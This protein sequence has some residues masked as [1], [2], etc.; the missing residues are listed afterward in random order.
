MPRWL[1]LRHQH[2]Q[3][4]AEFERK[5][6]A[7]HAEFKRRVEAAR[8]LLLTKHLREESQL[9]VSHAQTPGPKHAAT[10]ISSRKMQPGSG[11]APATP[12]R[13]GTTPA[14]PRGTLKAQQ[15]QKPPITPSKLSRPS[16]VPP[17]PGKL[18]DRPREAT[19]A[20]IDLCSD[21]EDDRP[22]ARRKPKPGVQ[23]PTARDRF[24]QAPTTQTEPAA[25]DTDDCMIVDQES[26]L[27]EAVQSGNE[28]FS[29][30]SASLSLFGGFSKKQAASSPVVMLGNMLTS[31][32]V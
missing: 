8:Q 6:E 13:S 21:D 26:P 14:T 10:A 1:A 30:P 31:C 18:R 4:V 29:I 12:S 19:V 24:T 16:Q 32:A 5:V 23:Q 9:H 3:Q 2:T 27:P 22:L 11:R 15:P 28:T 20:V 17:T 25:E 7:D